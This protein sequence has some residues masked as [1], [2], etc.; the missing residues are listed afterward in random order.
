[1][2]GVAAEKVGELRSASRAE[3][4]KQLA[5][6]RERPMEDRVEHANL[7]LQYEEEQR[8]HMRRKDEYEKY[9]AETRVA[10]AVSHTLEQAK[11]Y[12]SIMSRL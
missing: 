10:Q 12:P 8:E 5:S 9:L 1:M 2:I 6:E 3:K 11:P 4:E 7:A